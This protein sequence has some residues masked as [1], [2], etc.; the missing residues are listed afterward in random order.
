MSRIYV[1]NIPAAYLDGDY[2]VTVTNVNDS[3]VY[4]ISTNALCYANA[5]LTNSQD[6]DQVNLAKAMYL[7]NLAANEFFGK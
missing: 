5:V 6:T 2:K 4:T 7:Y 1:T 3:T